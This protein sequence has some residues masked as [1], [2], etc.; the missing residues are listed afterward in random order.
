MEK[1]SLDKVDKIVIKNN[2]ITV[3]YEDGVIFTT[4]GNATFEIGLVNDNDQPLVDHCI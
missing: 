1:Y 4:K 2:I 3:T